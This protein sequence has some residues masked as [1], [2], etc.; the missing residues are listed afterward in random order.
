MGAGERDGVG[1]GNGTVSL[2]SAWAGLDR[3]SA[4][5]GISIMNSQDVR[6]GERGDSSRV[7]PT[8]E[9]WYA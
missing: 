8:V 4:G 7:V 3:G 9:V 1:E 5:V 6:V 2:G